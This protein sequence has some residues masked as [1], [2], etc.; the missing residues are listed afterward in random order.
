MTTDAAAPALT[1]AD[2]WHRP[3]WPYLEGY[4]LGGNAVLTLANER[5]GTRFTYQVELATTERDGTPRE[6]PSLWFVRVLTSADNDDPRAYTYL[7]T[8]R[9]ERPH[10]RY[11]HGRA[12]PVGL[13]APSAQGFDWLWRRL[14]RP[15][16]PPG[17]HV[18]WWT[19]GRCSACGRLLTSEWAT[20]G[21][22]ETCAR[23]RGVSLP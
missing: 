6:E 3:A 21:L 1:P 7:G 5:T 18:R 16:D 23:R 9:G 11:A 13:D 10:P 12:S 20:V 2:A 19:A 8:L 17:D 14:A 4:L 15:N 22:G